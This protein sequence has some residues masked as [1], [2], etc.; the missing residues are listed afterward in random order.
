MV[1]FAGMAIAYEWVHYLTHTNYVPRGA[2]YRR[3]WRNHRLHHYKNEHH[4]FGFIVPWV[5]TA[6]GT[7]PALKDVET[8]P[9]CRN[10]G[11]DE[12]DLQKARSVSDGP[13]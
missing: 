10:L 7:D 12:D 3:L 11:V 1:A 6:F 8:S 13:G 4:W 9:T 5:D 2:Y